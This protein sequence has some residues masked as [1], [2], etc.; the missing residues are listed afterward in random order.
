MQ[1][2]SLKRIYSL[3]FKKLILSVLEMRVKFPQKLRDCN[4]WGPLGLANSPNPLLLL[5][6]AHEDGSLKLYGAEFAERISM[7]TK[8]DEDKST[9]STLEKIIPY[10]P[11]PQ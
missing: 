1:N 3:V 8:L 2:L 11:Q 4:V 6:S 10:D 9:N 7:K 5:S